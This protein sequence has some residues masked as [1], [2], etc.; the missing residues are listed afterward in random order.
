VLGG[1]IVAAAGT[2]EQRAEILS[3]LSSGTRRVAFAHAEPGQRWGDGAAAVRARSTDGVWT[4][5]GT[6]E[7]V[8]GGDAETLVVS[9]ALDSGGTG[10][11]LVDPETT[12]RTT[13]TAYDGSRVSRVVCR[14]TPATP[15]GEAGADATA[16]IAKVLDL[17][18]IAACH[19]ALGGME[20]ALETTTSYLRSRRQF[21]VTLNTFQALTFRAADMYVA[22]ELTRSLVGWAAMVAATGDPAR[23]ADAAARA[24]LQVSRAGRHVGLEAIQ[25]HGGIGMTAEY[26]VGNVA[27]HLTA[28]DHL[29]GD[30]QHHLTRLMAQVED[31]EALDPLAG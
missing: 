10:L 3:A 31:H 16:T 24:G 30:G 1:G 26:V 8:L 12:E 19:E 20:V 9:A 7:P 5:E 15:L 14:A 28:L 11:F 22:L 23:V 13:T 18:R 2:A 17:A 4:L 27:A 21:G 29:L 25:L 6:K